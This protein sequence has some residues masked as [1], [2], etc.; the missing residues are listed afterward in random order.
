VSSSKLVAL[1]LAL[2]ALVIAAPSRAHDVGISRGVYSVAGAVVSAE[3]T[4]SR[5]EILG[6]VPDLDPDRDGVMMQEE[7]DRARAAIERAIV[8][9]VDVKG[10]GAACPGSLREATLVEEDG[11]TVRAAYRCPAPP[12]KAR[13]ELSMLDDLPH[14]HRHIARAEAPA[15]EHVLFR[16]SRSLDLTG[17]SGAVSSDGASGSEPSSSPGFLGFFLM[18]IEHILLGYDHLVF[19]LGLVLVGGRLRSMLLVITAFTVAHSIT[20]GVAA[21]GL[22]RPSPSVI[23]PLIA[24]SIAYVG[25]ENF[26]VKDAEKRWRITLPF[27]LIHGFGF[28]GALGE[29]RLPAPEIPVA[30]VSFNLGVEVGQVAVLALVLPLILAAKKQKQKWFEERGMKAVSAVIVLMGLFWFVTRVFDIGA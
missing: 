27:G 11:I 23:E 9:R 28:A 17:G 14:G 18:G 21:L 20:L 13:V 8:A 3:L 12:A 26:F 1:A 5:R 25:V 7:V 2:A 4:F 6:A 30:L 15:G 29:I 22:F 10:D 16:S 19:L 24:L